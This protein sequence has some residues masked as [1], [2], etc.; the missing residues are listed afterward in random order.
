ME[1]PHPPCPPGVG[2]P[3]PNFTT[4][5]LDQSTPRPSHG[6]SVS[7]VIERTVHSASVTVA[8]RAIP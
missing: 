8:G 2:Y 5:S 1:R 3:G 6:T 7:C 4:T